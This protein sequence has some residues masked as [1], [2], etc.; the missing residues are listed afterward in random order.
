MDNRFSRVLRSFGWNNPNRRGP[1][2][3]FSISNNN[4][5]SGQYRPPQAASADLH[6]NLD[7][8]LLFDDPYADSGLHN[9]SANP[10]K[11]LTLAIT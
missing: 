8:A 4:Q 7:E 6:E 2:N 10:Y 11:S 3:F 1:F 5:S 9:S